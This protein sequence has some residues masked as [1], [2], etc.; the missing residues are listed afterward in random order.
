LGLKRETD[1]V[2]ND[3]KRYDRDYFDRWYRDERHRVFSAAERARRAAMAVAATEYVLDRPVRTVL[4]IGAGEGTWLAP[5]RRIRP[6][7]RYVGV[8]PSSYAVTRFGT[9]RNI[10]LGSI[11]TIDPGEFDG[12]FD[13]VLA[14]GFLNLFPIARIAKALRR[15]RPLIGGVAMLEVFTADDPLTGDIGHYVREGTATYRRMFNRLNLLPVGLH[16]Y[17]AR[18]AAGDLAALETG[19]T[20]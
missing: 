11:E 16:L 1:P 10:R 20:P 9:R 4:D 6:R 2:A 7:I 14:V 18:E 17:A 12:P 3:G 8:D 15:I 19:L 5:L 13:L